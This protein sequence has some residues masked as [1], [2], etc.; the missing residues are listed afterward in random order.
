MTVHDKFKS[1]L[2][3][4]GMNDGHAEQVMLRYFLKE[5]SMLP[6]GYNL[7]WQ[8]HS[9]AYPT[10]IYTALASLLF[11]CA[12]KYIDANIPQAWFRPMFVG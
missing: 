12:L 7:T 6:T 9:D 2:V 4:R 1:M 8:D 5:V 11:E 10:P 3:K